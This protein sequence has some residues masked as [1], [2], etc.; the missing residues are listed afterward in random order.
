[1]SPLRSIW[2]NF[3]PRDLLWGVVWGSVAAATYGIVRE[4][5]SH[6]M[7]VLRGATDL[8]L[9]AGA[10]ILVASLAVLTL[11]FPL[12]FRKTVCL[13]RSWRVGLVRG[14]TILWGLCTFLSWLDH[15]RVLLFVLAAAASEIMMDLRDPMAGWPTLHPPNC[16]CPTL[17][18]VRRVGT[19]NVL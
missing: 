19:G 10:P 15:R 1:M 6:G 2:T 17:R 18:G 9:R 8:R 3:R 11:I 14:T 5:F 4:S 12:F 16:G 13:V 7:S